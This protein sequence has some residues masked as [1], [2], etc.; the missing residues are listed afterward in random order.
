MEFKDLS[1]TFH[2]DKV[3]ECK[4]FYVK[5]FNATVSFDAGWYVTIHFKSNVNPY[6][7]LSFQQSEKANSDVFSGGATLNLMVEDVDNAYSKMKQTDIIIKDEIANHEW[8]DRSFSVTDPIGNILY[9]YSP[10]PMGEKYK[11]AIKEEII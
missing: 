1:I 7:F 3:Q 6:I 11:D 4:D 2:T 5:Y 9:I 8:G 10:R